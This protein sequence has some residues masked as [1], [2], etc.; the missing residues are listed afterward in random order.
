MDRC[1]LHSAPTQGVAADFDDDHLAWLEESLTKV[2]QLGGLFTPELF[3][4]VLA[5]LDETLPAESGS[6]T[7]CH[8]DL[9]AERIVVDEGADAGVV[10]D[11]AD[12][13]VTTTQNLGPINLRLRSR[14]T[15]V[16]CCAPDVPFRP[17]SRG[18][19]E[20]I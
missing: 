18:Q 12:S 1:E 16:G 2:R 7:L 14:H 15:F 6:R 17:A 9:L 20:V 11:W 3:H 5:R 4:L 13:T 10:I 8:G 19:L